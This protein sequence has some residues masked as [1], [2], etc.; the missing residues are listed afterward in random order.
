MDKFIGGVKNSGIMEQERV[1]L[2]YKYFFILEH[3]DK[4]EGNVRKHIENNCLK[5]LKEIS[6]QL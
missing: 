5:R 4:I 6:E 2:F 1:D 3:V